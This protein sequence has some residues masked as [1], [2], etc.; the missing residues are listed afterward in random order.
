MPSRGKGDDSSPLQMFALCR[1]RDQ[2]DAALEAGVPR[3][4]LDFED[5][6]LYADLVKHIKASSDRS[7]VWLAT[8]RIQ[9][10]GEA[11]FFKLIQRAEPHGVLIRNLGAI[12]FFRDEGM[13]VTGDFSLNVANPLTAEILKKTGLERLTISYD[14]NIEQ[15]V[16]LLASAPP[17]WFELTLHQHM[18]MFH[19]EHCVF[20]AFLSTG[21][22]YRDCGRP[23]DRH[24]VKLRDRVGQEH[25]LK[26]DSGCR[27]TVFNSRAQT[28][29]EF[30]DRFRALGARVFRVEF[31]D[32]SAEE[33]RRT[34]A[35]YRALLR[36]ELTGQQLWQQLKLH[37]QL[38]V[39]R[40]QL[41]GIE[42][43]KVFPKA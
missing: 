2:I 1:T 43:R 30:L 11:G 16:D 31:V 29:A 40:G 39:T 26:A 13:P 6:R 20:C 4:Y 5:I 21:K 3:L 17:S 36:G 14:L 23:C 37:S 7:E 35:A 12:A 18:P 15:V 42:L 9:K 25:P 33:V 19:M 41:E 22:D 10:S 34:L 24:E 27:N 28:G 8:P 32:E 38:G